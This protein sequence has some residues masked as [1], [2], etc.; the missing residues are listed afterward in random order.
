ME[1]KIE[2]IQGSTTKMREVTYPGGD[3]RGRSHTSKIQQ[4]FNPEEGDATELR[5]NY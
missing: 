4:K 3:S 5:Y 1:E 2:E